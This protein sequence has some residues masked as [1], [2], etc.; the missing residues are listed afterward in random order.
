MMSHK[1]VVIDLSL[2]V[3]AVAW[4]SPPNASL[5]SVNRIA[6]AHY[7]DIT[8]ITYKACDMHYHFLLPQ[9]NQRLLHLQQR[10]Y[11]YS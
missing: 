3:L 2:S 6:C 10:D 5:A 1:C 7:L 9:N 11:K 8:C 4:G